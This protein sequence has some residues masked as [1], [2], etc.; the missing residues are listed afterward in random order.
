L[1]DRPIIVLDKTL[2]R[3]PLAPAGARVNNGNGGPARRNGM[4]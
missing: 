2:R 1:V 4:A 3:L